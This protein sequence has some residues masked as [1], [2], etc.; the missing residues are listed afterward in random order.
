MGSNSSNGCRRIYEGT[1]PCKTLRI[2]QTAKYGRRGVYAKR[3]FINSFIISYYGLAGSTYCIRTI[4]RG[5]VDSKQAT[6]YKTS[7]LHSLLELPINSFID[8]IRITH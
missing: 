7:I 3:G 1:V 5:Y 4:L 2:H 6:E 8:F